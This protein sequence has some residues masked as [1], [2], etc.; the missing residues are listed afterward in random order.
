MT[1]TVQYL[2]I[3]VAKATLS[4]WVAGNRQPL[5]TLPNTPEGWQALATR[6]TPSAATASDPAGLHLVL[7]PTGGYEAGLARFALAQGWT[8]SLVHPVRVRHWADAQ[9]RRSKTDRQDAGLL[10]DYGAATQPPAWHPLEE[11]VA[12]LENLLRRKADLEHLL[13]QE[14]NRKAAADLRPGRSAAVTGSIARVIAALEEELRQ[15]E[16]AIAAHQ[17]QH[18]SLQAQADLLD[19]VPGVGNKTVLPLLV[20]V[21]RYHALTQGKG[22]ARG[23]TAYVGLDPRAYESGTSVHRHPG[24]SRMG[25]RDLRRRLFM[26]ALGGVRGNNA[27]K[28][29]YQRLVGRGKKKKLAL[30]AAARKLLNWAWAVFS[31]NT[32]FAP[33]R[34]Q[35]RKS[36]QTLT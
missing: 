11:E 28:A 16:Q 26:A 25:D 12:M 32:A 20:L 14:R 7:E 3:D 6:L 19:S 31:T 5:G 33:E 4:V 13:Q 23:L 34:V 2:G 29:F 9:G 1:S 10:A 36:A 17:E 21:R 8:V 27:L 22:D 35:P 18:P 24:I 15:I 30:V